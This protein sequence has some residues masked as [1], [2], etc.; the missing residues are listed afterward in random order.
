MTQIEGHFKPVFWP[1]HCTDIL[2]LT[3]AVQ[4]HLAL[5]TS[6][7]GGYI[8]HFD[9]SLEADRAAEGTAVVLADTVA[10]WKGKTQVHAL[11]FQNKNSNNI[12]LKC[13]KNT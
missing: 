11:F 4:T 5:R 13:S 9:L 3:S 12:L 6:L 2:W 7:Y 8:V 1:F 10:D